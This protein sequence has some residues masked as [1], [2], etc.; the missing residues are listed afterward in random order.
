[1]GDTVM[2]MVALTEKLAAIRADMLK[3]LNADIF[4][5]GKPGTPQPPKD[6]RIARR[7]RLQA[8]VR[9]SD[10]DLDPDW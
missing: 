3:R 8:L 4:N 9:V 2:A 5:D 1:M 10:P 7:E 6:P